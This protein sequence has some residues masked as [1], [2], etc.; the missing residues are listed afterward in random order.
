MDVQ[1]RVKGKREANSA[2]KRSTESRQTYTDGKMVL[3]QEANETSAETVMDVESKE[4]TG[5]C[6]LIQ[7]KS[8]SL[9]TTDSNPFC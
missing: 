7:E 1:T 4:Q 2:A 9:L 3:I 5:G 8:D 6:K